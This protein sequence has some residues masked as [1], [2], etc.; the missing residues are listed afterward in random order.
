MAS[1]SARVRRLFWI[2][3]TPMD[4]PTN[5]RENKSRITQQ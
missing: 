5:R 4:Q 3:G 2:A 1:S